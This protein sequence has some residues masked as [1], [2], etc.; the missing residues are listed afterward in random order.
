MDKLLTVE[1]LVGKAEI[2]VALVALVVVVVATA[3]AVFS[4]NVLNSPVLWTGAK[5][6]PETPAGPRPGRPHPPRDAAGGGG[7]FAPAA[8]TRPRW[9]SVARLP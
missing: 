7:A 6:W 9:R 2:A 1:R 5:T 3:V 4:R 8:L